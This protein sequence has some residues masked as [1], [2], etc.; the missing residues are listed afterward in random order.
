MKEEYE[1][2]LEL[3]RNEL[4][5]KYDRYESRPRSHEDYN[6]WLSQFDGNGKSEWDKYWLDKMDEGYHAELIEIK[7]NL[8]DELERESRERD[9]DSHSQLQSQTRDAQ[10]K[11]P[12]KESLSMPPITTQ[13]QLMN[14]QTYPQIFD[15]RNVTASKPRL[16]SDLLEIHRVK[17]D[18][19]TQTEN[20][21][22]IPL[23]Q[24]REIISNFKR[25]VHRAVQTAENDFK[26]HNGFDE[27]HRNL[28]IPSDPT[29]G[30]H[31][32]PDKV[33]KL[34]RLQ[35]TTSKH[36]L[37]HALKVQNEAIKKEVNRIEI[38]F[39]KMLPY[40]AQTQ[41]HGRTPDMKRAVVNECGNKDEES[42]RVKFMEPQ[43]RSYMN[44]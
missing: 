41:R 3:L 28:V 36:I 8:I 31:R 19:Q 15:H 20:E 34:L 40:C 10:P 35:M 43:A 1:R 16:S 2:R 18:H 44:K 30:Y 17:T 14:V 26:F 6:I 39:D 42:K 37:A 32:L 12:V 7:R 5:K 33:D 9:R 29:R 11:D 38:R 21:Q 23:S 4:H 13:P 24:V 22:S 27:P 25:E